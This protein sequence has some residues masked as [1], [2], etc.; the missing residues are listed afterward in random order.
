MAD[1]AAEDPPPG[2]GLIGGRGGAKVRLALLSV[3]ELMIVLDFSIVT[4]PPS[5]RS[6]TSHPP[7]RMDD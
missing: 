4:L 2:T 6:C 5:I 1:S 7:T 3:A